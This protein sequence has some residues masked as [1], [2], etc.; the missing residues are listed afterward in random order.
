M[1]IFC[2][3]LAQSLKVSS[4]LVLPPVEIF[5]SEVPHLKG[6]IQYYLIFFNN[7]EG[8]AI[9]IEEHSAKVV[10]LLLIPLLKVHVN[11]YS[12]TI[13]CGISCDTSYLIGGTKDLLHCLKIFKTNSF[14]D[15]WVI[16]ALTGIIMS[17]AMIHI[18]KTPKERGRK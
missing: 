18:D 8:L 11:K 7:F 15:I 17:V 5:N 6:L 2:W 16:F 14:N 13:S 12:S 1:K 3:F 10:V 4:L 9:I